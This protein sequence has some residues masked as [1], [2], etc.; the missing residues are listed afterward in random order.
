MLVQVIKASID[1]SDMTGM[2]V[3]KWKLQR[4]SENDKLGDLEADA[5]NQR[6]KNVI[7]LK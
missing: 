5:D 2:I 3:P 7:H 6:E 1:F 4:E